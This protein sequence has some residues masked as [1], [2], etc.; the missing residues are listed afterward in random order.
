MKDLRVAVGQF[1]S[2]EDWEANLKACAGLLD[3]AVAGNA[4]LLVLP[5]GAMALFVDD[6]VR[7][8]QA[9][10]PLDGPFVT[11]LAQ[12]TRGTATTVI[13]GMHQPADDGRVINTL[14]ALRDGEIVA[15]YRKLHLYDAFGRRESDNVLAS[16]DS[17]V[18]LDCAGWKVGLMTC[19]DVR[20]PEM[21]RLLADQGAQVVALPAAW[22]RGP[23]KEWHWE[24]MVTARALENTYYVAASGEC[25]RRNI[26]A[27]M[28]V[29]PLGVCRARLGDTPGLLWGTASAEDLAQARLTLPVL[30][31]RRFTVNPSPRSLDA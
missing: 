29:D 12:R 21:A 4:D 1:A 20:F 31:N 13:V 27:S 9:A 7:I 5:E 28:F 3:E 18:V 19:Y 24:V 23:A 22:V 17:P 2:G 11:G 30:A 6:P 25:G 15:T 14:V 16:D 26:G 10:Q 8:R